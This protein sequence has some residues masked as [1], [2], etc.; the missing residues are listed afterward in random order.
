MNYLGTYEELQ[1]IVAK[2]QISGTWEEKANNQK[3]FKCNS[4]GI[5]NWW[6]TKKGTLT[7]QGVSKAK[8]R[9][10]TAGSK[11]LEAD[12]G[13]GAAKPKLNN[14][15]FV[16]Y[17]HDTEAKTH[18]EAMLRR[19]GLEPL[20]LDQLPSKGQTIIEKLE[21]YTKML[22]LLLFSRHQMMKGTAN[23]I[24]TKRFVVLGKT[25]FLSWV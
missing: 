6:N 17:G 25:L 5:L 3:Q 19:W 18:L 12:G 20:I 16:V 7:F 2:T 21:E 24:Q 11:Q 9:L 13:I 4:G 1:S 8:D 23:I 14:K 10:E 22:D 15:V